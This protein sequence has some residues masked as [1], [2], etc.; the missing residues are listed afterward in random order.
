MDTQDFLTSVRQ[1]EQVT[2]VVEPRKMTYC[3]H[4][5]S[6]HFVHYDKGSLT[7]KEAV[8]LNYIHNI[9]YNVRTADIT[10]LPAVPV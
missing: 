5:Q 1:K 10:N 3:P 6:T 9:L 7:D 8:L 2:K 4:Y